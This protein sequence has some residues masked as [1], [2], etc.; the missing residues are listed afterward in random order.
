MPTHHGSPT[1]RHAHPERRG[2]SMFQL[3]AAIGIVAVSMTVCLPS[4]PV[5][6]LE[7]ERPLNIHAFLCRPDSADMNTEVE[8][9]EILVDLEMRCLQ[10]RPVNDG[11]FEFSVITDPNHTNEQS[12]ARIDASLPPGLEIRILGFEDSQPL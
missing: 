11:W 7:D 2:F 12:C 3:L 4:M 10:F 6:E 8:I 1:V 9:R 5:P